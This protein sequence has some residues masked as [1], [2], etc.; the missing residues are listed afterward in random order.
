MRKMKLEKINQR[1]P[2][3]QWAAGQTVF[4]LH[5]DCYWLIEDT[6]VDPDGLLECPSCRATPMDFAPVPWWREDL[7]LAEGPSAS[8]H[9]WKN[10]PIRGVPGK[11]QHLPR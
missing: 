10:E 2:F 8:E 5:C 3:N 6:A 4:C 11:Y 9:K 1:D 7:T